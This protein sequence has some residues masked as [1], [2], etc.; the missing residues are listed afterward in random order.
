M[1]YVGCRDAEEIRSRTSALRDAGFPT[2]VEQA[3]PEAKEA[4]EQW[5]PPEGPLGIMKRLK[6]ELDPNGML[7]PGRLFGKI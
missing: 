1:T 6:N 5:Q 3:A 4:V 2:L 7:N